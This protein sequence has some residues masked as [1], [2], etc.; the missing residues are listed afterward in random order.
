MY[1]CDPETKRY[2]Q[3]EGKKGIRSVKNFELKEEETRQLVTYRL[4][5]KKYKTFIEKIGKQQVVGNSLI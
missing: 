2:L 5:T 1:F 4:S 3:R